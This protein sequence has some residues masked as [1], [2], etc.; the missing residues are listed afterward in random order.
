MEEWTQNQNK[1]C[2]LKKMQPCKSKKGTY[3]FKVVF[4]F[5]TTYSSEL[6]AGPSACE[7]EVY[8]CS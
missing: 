6:Q 1:L 3:D 5:L 4:I 2:M 7:L 8:R